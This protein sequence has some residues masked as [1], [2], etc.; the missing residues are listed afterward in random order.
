MVLVEVVG[1]RTGTG[2]ML[3]AGA[4]VLAVAVATVVVTA[5]AGDQVVTAEDQVAPL[6][7]IGDLPRGA[8][9]GLTRRRLRRSRRPWWSRRPRWPRWR[10]KWVR[11]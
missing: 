4:V 11:E 8:G 3:S 6:E 10:R 7:V 5:E 9:G 2:T 1:A